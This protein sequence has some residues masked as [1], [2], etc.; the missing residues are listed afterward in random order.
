VIGVA[1]FHEARR[2]PPPRVHRPEYERADARAA[3][4]PAAPEAAPSMAQSRAQELGT[5]HGRREY[6]PVSRT[7]FVRA[8]PHPV[9]VTQVRYDDA[10]ALAARGIG[11][12]H[13]RRYSRDEPRAFPGG[14]VPDPPR[15]W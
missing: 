10:R 2:M 13:D 6:A 12:R 8:S 1:V 15:G 11:P 9:Q 4:A 5:G 3:D 14:F 7:G